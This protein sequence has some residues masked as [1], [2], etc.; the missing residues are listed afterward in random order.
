MA[1]RCV[2]CDLTGR[3]ETQIALVEAYCKAQGLWRDANTPPPEFTAVIEIDLSA[4][5]P[6]VSGPSRPQD[7]VALGDAPGAFRAY[8]ST[9]AKPKGIPGFVAQGRRRGDRRDH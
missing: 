3:D 1:R 7:R 6:S 8:V 9:T 5:E 4:V 2:T